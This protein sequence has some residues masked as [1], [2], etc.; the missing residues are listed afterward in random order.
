MRNKF[1]DLLTTEAEK[2]EKIFLIVGDLGFG[3]IEKFKN[4]F[5]D[6]YLNVG[7][8]EQNLAGIAAGIASEGMH[9]FIYSI[10]NF[11]TYR[12]AEFLRNDID[13]HNYPV[14]VVA[15]G[16]G[17][18]YGMLGYSH[19]GIQDYGLM[20][21]MPNFTI[22][23]PS[24]ELE[25][26]HSLKLLFKKPHPSYLRLDK[27]ANNNFHHDL[28]K[29]KGGEWLKIIENKKSQNVFLTTG[30]TVNI[31]RNK[32]KQKKYRN[33]SLYSLPVWGSKYKKTQIKYLKKFD[34]IITVED[35]LH[36][37]GF[38]SWLLEASPDYLRSKIKNLALSKK[39]VGKVGSQDYLSKYFSI[40]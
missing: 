14:T 27:N 7:V 18:S 21:M 16:S 31:A 40:F 24:D 13:Y 26:E 17:L 1:I 12:C 11:I 39:V 20:R 33:F 10:G 29:I 2:N 4:K 32:I 30:S 35:H 19:H 38:G 3:V 22:N 6:R 28:N 34:Q 8:A 23:S 36:D 15:V 37:N 25:L 5:P 9:V